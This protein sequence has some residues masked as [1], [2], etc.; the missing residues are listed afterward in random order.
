LSRKAIKFK[1]QSVSSDV[2]ITI[3][4]TRVKPRPRNKF[5]VAGTAKSNLCISLL[6]PSH[7]QT[8]LIQLV[9]SH[10]QP[11]ILIKGVTPMTSKELYNSYARRASW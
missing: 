4:E 3:Q 8:L 9:I 10:S 11:L 5:Q 2:R 6:L 1:P 7:L